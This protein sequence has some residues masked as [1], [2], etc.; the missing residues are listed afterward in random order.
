MVK[1]GEYTEVYKI[2]IL[3]F[4]KSFFG[5]HGSLISG[6][7]PDDDQDFSVSEET[8]SEWLKSP[9][10]LYVIIFDD[11]LVGFLRLSYKGSNVVWIEDIFVDKMYR[12]KGIATNA[13]GIAESIIKSDSQYTSI[14]IDVVPRNYAA[15]KLYHKL[16]Y[17]TLSLVTVRKELYDNKR[18]LKFDFNGI[19][20]KY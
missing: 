2:Q 3:K 17:D 13:I 19:D 4:I 7:E 15:L 8:L 18:D 14:C 12:N 10:K 5:F 20:F 11:L 6:T 16:G 1:L 9:S